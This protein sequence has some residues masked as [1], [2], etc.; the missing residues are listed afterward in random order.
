[1]ATVMHYRLLNYV[2]LVI[3]A[4]SLFVAQVAMVICLEHAKR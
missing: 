2:W 4:S 3:V 1:M